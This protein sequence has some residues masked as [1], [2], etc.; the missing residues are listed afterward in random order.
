MPGE[1]DI[2][3]AVGEISDG[4]GFGTDEGDSGLGG[5]DDGDDLG[6]GGSDDAVGEG[7]PEGNTP[8]EVPEAPETPPAPAPAPGAPDLSAPPKTWKADAAAEWATLPERTR[9]EI[10]KREEDMFRGL[11]MYRGDAQIGKNFSQVLQP[12]MQILQQHNINPYQQVQGL[13]QAHYTLAMGTPEQKQELFAKLAQD[14]GV[15]VSALPLAPYEDP[16]VA[17]LRQQLQQQQ[18]QINQWQQ[19]QQQ[20]VQQKA[21]QSVEA[22]AN[23][24]ANAYFDEVADDIAQLLQSGVAKDLQDA[25]DKAVWANPVTRA[26]EQAR[27]TTQAT[28]K[29]RQEAE[30]RAAKAKQAMRA[31]VRTSAKSG[32]AATPLGSIDDTL[33]ETLAAI[34]GKG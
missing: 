17:G 25:Y 15:D 26:K 5:V 2:D 9:A 8:P 33:S 27:L 6:L 29:A 18:N 34:R 13:M 3:S 4:L 16:A 1:F 23:D 11:E 31:N 30:A 14:Y 28:E 7:A 24:P 19:S 21:A 32:S 20:Q 22:F 10:H 12:Y